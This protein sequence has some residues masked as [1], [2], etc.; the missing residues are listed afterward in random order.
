[1]AERLNDIDLY[2]KI[3]LICAFHAYHH[4]QLS[5]LYWRQHHWYQPLF[6]QAASPYSRFLCV[7]N[8]WCIISIAEL[9]HMA[10]TMFECIPSSRAKINAVLFDLLTAFKF[11][12]FS[13]NFFTICPSPVRIWSDIFRYEL[14]QVLYSFDDSFYLY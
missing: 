1:M 13:I 11:A 7:I 4:S 12:P 5:Y 3:A 2:L 14:S 9:F 8:N 10:I 6:Q